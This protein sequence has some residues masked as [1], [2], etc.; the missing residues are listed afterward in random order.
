[1]SIKALTVL[2]RAVPARFLQVL[3]FAGDPLP[4]I[5]NNVANL[6]CD[7]NL[8]NGQNKKW[9]NTPITLRNCSNKKSRN[10]KRN[11]KNITQSLPYLKR[12]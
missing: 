1:M 9:N 4:K 6:I 5:A 10:R 3:V 8:E 2:G 11:S 12:L 7:N